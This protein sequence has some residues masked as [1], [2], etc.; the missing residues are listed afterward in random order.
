[1]YRNLDEEIFLAP[2]SII[3]RALCAQADWNDGDDVPQADD[4]DLESDEIDYSD[5]ND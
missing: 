1:M 3:W 2:E 4:E 5:G